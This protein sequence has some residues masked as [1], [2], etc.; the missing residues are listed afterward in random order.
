MAH[1]QTHVCHR[2]CVCGVYRAH[3]LQATGKRHST[4]PVSVVSYPLDE[5]AE[6]FRDDYGGWRGR[7]RDT[8]EEVPSLVD[9]IAFY[10]DFY[11]RSKMEHDTIIMSLIY[12]ERLIK[13]TNGFI[14]PVPEN[15]KSLLFSCMV[16]ASKV[17]DDMS[18][19]NI[20]FSNVCGRGR[21]KNQLA[22]FTL[23]RINQLELALLKSLNFNV[24]V[25]A[26]EYA[27]YYFLIRSML[28]KSGLL[29]ENDDP[30]LT[31][32]G[33][34]Y[35]KELNQ[36][37]PE[38]SRQRH[39]TPP[40]HPKRTKKQQQ[41]KSKKEKEKQNS[42]S[43]NNNNNNRRSHSLTDYFWLNE[44]AARNGQSSQVCLEQLVS[45]NR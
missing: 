11:G 34:N 45:M 27:K 24:K 36:S 17:W 41:Q 21:G 15:W 32:P 25:R 18:M 43:N 30:L 16:L 31:P 37:F 6:I 13:E 35:L 3:I 2:K 19:W 8:E 40:K 23:E 14:A 20:D 4:S 38:L 42:A 1:F 22:S 44:D 9:I 10:C 7:R 5:I 12:V 26:S 28:M 39:P 33:T 29:H